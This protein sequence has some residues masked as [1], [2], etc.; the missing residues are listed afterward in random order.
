MVAE[1]VLSNYTQIFASVG[2]NAYD[3]DA[4]HKCASAIR[5]DG[6]W[7]AEDAILATANFLQRDI[8]IYISTQQISPL[9]Y[10]ATIF[11]P[12]QQPVKLAFYEPGH[13]C[14]VFDVYDTITSADKHLNSAL[15]SEN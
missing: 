7:A 10:N 9:I 2:A 5:K 13:Y 4:A 11:G 15:L 8:I 6:A 1:Y 14:P 12:K 3:N